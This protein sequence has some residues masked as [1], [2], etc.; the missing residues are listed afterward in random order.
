MSITIEKNQGL[1]L[2]LAAAIPTP[3]HK[4]R[5][6]G[7]YYKIRSYQGGGEFFQHDSAQLIL[8]YLGDF[9]PRATERPAA[10][11]G[12][13]VLYEH[14]VSGQDVCHT[15][16]PLNS[17]V[18]IPASEIARLQDAIATLKA[19]ETDPATDPGKRTIIAAFRLPDPRKDPE[20]YRLYGPRG[21]RR[22]LVLW[23]V[24]KEQGT[25][26]TPQDAVLQ[27]PQ[28][29]KRGWW[30][31]LLWVLLASLALLLL[32]LAIAKPRDRQLSILSTSPSD[33]SDASWS[34][35]GTVPN[36][37]LVSSRSNDA[38]KPADRP[39]AMPADAAGKPADR[40]SAMPADA[41]GKPADRPSAMPADAAGKPADR[42]S[43]MPADAA[44]K[45]ADR[46]SAVPADAA[47][48]PADRP[49][50]VPADAAGKPA[51][52]P[53][54]MPA[55]AA[56]KT[57]PPPDPNQPYIEIIANRT[58]STPS[59]GLI[60]VDLQAV[61]HSPDGSLQPLG[62]VT[63]WQVDHKVQKNTTG[64]AVTDS[65]APVRLSEG[66]HQVQVTAT[67][68]NGQIATGEAEVTANIKRT[69][70]TDVKVKP[71]TPPSQASP[72]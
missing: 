5:D 68:P 24:E 66:K 7:G 21:E 13:E 11:G 45:P 6:A 4:G 70:S 30:K 57:S 12:T 2:S 44:G 51:D 37:P 65:K 40:P 50:A 16:A 1:C 43:A 49:S 46:P 27:V 18:E 61:L 55:D 47:G 48:K 19:K 52:R 71:K 14:R 34:P 31:W 60:E 20:L 54:A 33:R 23:G 36:T 41:A 32:W 69:E 17:G 29:A 42:P 64:Q 15:T 38:S 3:L 56:G 35:D 62:R 26:L 58:A 67:L 22:L 9:L 53:S 72:R 28:N 8:Q 59:L 10:A 39:S 25:S 63:T